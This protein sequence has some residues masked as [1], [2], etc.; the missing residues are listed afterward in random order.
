MEHIRAYYIINE[1]THQR[2]NNKMR[3]REAGPREK[4][5]FMQQGKNHANLSSRLERDGQ[6]N[7]LQREKTRTTQYILPTHSYTHIRSHSLIPPF[8]QCL[9]LC[10]KE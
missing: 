5:M 7:A 10:T 4:R 1:L 3:D 9:R 6:T 8:S 2:I